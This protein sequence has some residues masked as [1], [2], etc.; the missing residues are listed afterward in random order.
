VQLDQGYSTCRD[1]VID[2]YVAVVSWLL[3]GENQELKKLLHHPFA[4]NLA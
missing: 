1:A 4:T 3:A 2:A